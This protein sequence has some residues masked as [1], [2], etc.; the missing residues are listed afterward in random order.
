MLFRSERKA[1]SS[2]SGNGGKAELSNSVPEEHGEIRSAD[3]RTPIID[4]LKNPSQKTERV[5]RRLAFKYALMDDELYRRTADGLFLKCLDED[6]SR[7]AMG[8]LHDGLCGTHQS[9][10]KM[11]WM[12]RRAGFYWPTMINDCFRYYKGCE[13]CQ[14]NIR[15]AS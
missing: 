2:N 11:K 4:Y 5:I 7:I 9:A 3:W 15:R 10:H 8:E 13:A 6:Q 14:A 1:E 12:L